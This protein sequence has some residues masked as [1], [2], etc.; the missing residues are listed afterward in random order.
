MS[1]NSFLGKWK[2][3]EQIERLPDYGLDFSKWIGRGAIQGYFVFSV[4]YKEE[5]LTAQ[6]DIP[7]GVDSYFSIYKGRFQHTKTQIKIWQNEQNPVKIKY[8]FENDLLPLKLF[9][10]TITFKKL[11]NNQ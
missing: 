4:Y 7:I 3:T 5:A 6:V 8:C 9:S 2:S 10:K 1:V 11:T